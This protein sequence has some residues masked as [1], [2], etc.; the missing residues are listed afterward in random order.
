MHTAFAIELL[1]AISDWQKGGDLKQSIRRGKRLKEICSS[2]PDKYR[3]CHL[4]CFRQVALPKG[5]VWDLLGKNKLPE[6]ISSWTFDAQ[7]A[8]AFKGGVPPDGQGYQ[9]T[10]F[11]LLPSPASVI[12]NLRA[13]YTDGSFCDAMERNKTSINGYHEGAGRYKND[14]SEVVLEIE[15]VTPEDVYLLGGYS[16]PLD[17]LVAQAAELIYRR[18]STPAER[19]AL[20]LHAK[21]AGLEDGP[22]WLSM[23]ATR[24]VLDKTKPRAAVLADLKRQQDQKLDSL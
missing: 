6:K 17:E 7:I 5:G 23:V 9:G 21:D 13:L 11:C 8:K 22:K 2:L 1:Q 12:V 20:L 15:N 24:R 14:Q 16:S 4:V 19:E 3:A 10:I 18:S